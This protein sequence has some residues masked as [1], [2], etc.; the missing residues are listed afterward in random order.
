MNKLLFL[1]KYKIVSKLP[2]LGWNKTSAENGCGAVGADE[3]TGG[4]IGA[5]KLVT[6]GGGKLEW[7]AADDA[8]CN[9]DEETGGGVG[10]VR[11]AFGAGDN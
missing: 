11:V 3:T 7:D 2:L 8:G 6:N 9:D 5:D 10:R 1:F 4:G